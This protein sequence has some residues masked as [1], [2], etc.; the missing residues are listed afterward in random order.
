MFLC[1]TQPTYLHLNIWKKCRKTIYSKDVK[2]PRELAP[3]RR[4]GKAVSPI[5]F[6]D[7]FHRPIFRF[8]ASTY[9][10]SVYGHKFSALVC[11]P[12]MGTSSKKVKKRKRRPNAGGSTSGGE[13]AVQIVKSDQNVRARAISPRLINFLVVKNIKFKIYTLSD[14]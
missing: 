3:V 13:L 8:L 4:T 10:L 7:R 5:D 12:G 2:I 9:K 14:V 6:R 1:A 11:F